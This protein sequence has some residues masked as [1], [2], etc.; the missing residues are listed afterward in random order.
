VAD[1]HDIVV[2]RI[3]QIRAARPVAGEEMNRAEAAPS[4]VNAQTDLVQPGKCTR[5]AIR[6]ILRDA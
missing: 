3:D 1:H 6:A 5:L 4:F 2:G